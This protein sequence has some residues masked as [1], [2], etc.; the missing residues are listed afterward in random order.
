MLRILKLE[1]IDDAVLRS[2]LTLLEALDT[3]IGFM[4]DKI[5][6]V[7]LNDEKVKLLITMPGLKYFSASL[8]VARS[9]TSIASVAIRS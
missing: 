7:A 3:Q 1:F 5:A 2:D 8:L 4:E 6:A 9:A